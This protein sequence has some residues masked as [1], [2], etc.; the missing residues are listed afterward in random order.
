MS[1]RKRKI[2]GRMYWVLDRRFRAPDGTVDRYRRVAQIQT[3]AAAEAEERRVIDTWN[4]HGTIAP[5][6]GPKPSPSPCPR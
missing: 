6:S 3:R 4:Q 1:V 2:E 5:M